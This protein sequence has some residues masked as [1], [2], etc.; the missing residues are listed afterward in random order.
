M[1][2]CKITKFFLEEL[3]FI[4]T[5]FTLIVSYIRGTDEECKQQTKKSRQHF[6]IPILSKVILK[7]K[8]MF[9]KERMQPGA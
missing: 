7:E 9:E 2:T 8:E 3:H 5:E 6:C 1:N 4:M